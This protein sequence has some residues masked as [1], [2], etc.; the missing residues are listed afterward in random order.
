MINTDFHDNQRVI[1][2]ALDAKGGLRTDLSPA[3]ATDIL[4][5]LNHPDV[6]LLLVDECGWSAERFESWFA[7]IVCQ[8]LLAPRRSISHG[9]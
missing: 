2:N 1:I 3:E 5:T 8:Q 4:W 7:D 9:R 6:W